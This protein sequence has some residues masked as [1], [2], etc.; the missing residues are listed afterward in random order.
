MN[1]ESIP[2][3]VNNENW[4]EEENEEEHGEKRAT[5]EKS[6]GTEKNREGKSNNKRYTL[7]KLLLYIYWEVRIGDICKSIEIWYCS[8]FVNI[9]GFV[10]KSVCL[11]EEIIEFW[12][13]LRILK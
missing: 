11:S 9:T 10:L 12:K 6:L 4:K 1:N 13:F 3:T 8:I 5:S 2:W 7:C